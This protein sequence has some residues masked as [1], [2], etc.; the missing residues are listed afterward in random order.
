MAALSVITSP[1][2]ITSVGIWR[3]GLLV[4]TRSRA[5]SSAQVA[6]STIV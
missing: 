6:P 3:I 4:A 2:G 5:A 1:S